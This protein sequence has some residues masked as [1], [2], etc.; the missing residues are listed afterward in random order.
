MTYGAHARQGA[1]GAEPG[2]SRPGGR[3]AR[4]REAVRQATLEELAR[5]GFDGLT[6]EGVASRAGVHRATVHRRWRNAAGLAADALDLAS[7]EPW[8]VPDTGE[9]RG[10]LR[11]L[12][13]MV[14]EHFNDPR[15]GAVSRGIV[16]AAVRDA[17]TARALHGFLAG[18][19]RQAAPVVER[20]VERGELPEGTD[21]EEVVRTAIAP[22]Y[23]RLFISGEPVDEGTA[24]RAADAALA[25]ARAGAFV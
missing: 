12:T 17:E 18:R 5:H 6:V 8:P 4:T 2:R 3:T 20:A 1:S 11:E 10:D 21:A 19:H 7:D 22:L 14:A 23:Y 9:V 16:A 13:T 24:V 25:A 15:D